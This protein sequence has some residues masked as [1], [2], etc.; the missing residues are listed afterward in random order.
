MV[1]KGLRDKVT[2]ERRPPGNQDNFHGDNCGQ[3]VTAEEIASAKALRSEYAWYVQ[4]TSRP[5]WVDGLRGQDHGK[6][7]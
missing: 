5:L 7:V 2:C 3:S 6:T 4:G 1:R